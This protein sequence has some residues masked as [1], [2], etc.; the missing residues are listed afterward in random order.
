LSFNA[1]MSVGSVA[2]AAAAS[3]EVVDGATAFPD[4][5][6]RDAN[7]ILPEVA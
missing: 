5:F 7:G 1:V 4:A 6:I 3:T 2:P